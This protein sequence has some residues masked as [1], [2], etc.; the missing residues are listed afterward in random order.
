MDGFTGL[1]GLNPTR[2][3]LIPLIKR[4]TPPKF[5]F[6]PPNP[7]RSSLSGAACTPLEIFPPLL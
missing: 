2:I 7:C 1:E 4:S 3:S 6:T 5:R